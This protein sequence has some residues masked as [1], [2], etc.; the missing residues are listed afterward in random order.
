[1]HVKS[2]YCLFYLYLSFYFFGHVFSQVV[3]SQSNLNNNNNKRE[4][5]IKI[6][7][8]LR[9]RHVGVDRFSDF[10]LLVRFFKEFS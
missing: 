7:E 5:I 8:L 4:I 1:M 3:S 10:I 6:R 2:H 9:H